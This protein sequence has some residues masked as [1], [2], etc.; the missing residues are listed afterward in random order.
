MKGTG[1]A[2]RAQ[3]SCVRHASPREGRSLTSASCTSRRLP[4][5]TSTRLTRR[6]W[7]AEGVAQSIGGRSSAHLRRLGCRRS[8][9]SARRS[10]AITDRTSS[11]T[12]ALGRPR[13]SAVR[14]PARPCSLALQSATFTI[15]MA[16]PSRGGKGH[17]SPARSRA[18]V[19]TLVFGPQPCRT[20]VPS[21]WTRRL[22][23]PVLSCR[24][25]NRASLGRSR[26]GVNATKREASPL[27]ASAPGEPHQRATRMLVK[28]RRS[29]TGSLPR[30]LNLTTFMLIAPCRPWSRVST[31][32]AAWRLRRP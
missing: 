30:T 7:Q 8:W 19:P 25:A 13:R 1:A 17:A 21:A 16:T 18:R 9:P 15:S 2:P 29:S 20:R 6:Q 23:A 12:S 26:Q 32:R 14:C 4:S 22:R 3:L 5:T 10:W 28:S 24:C 11:S 27:A 31:R